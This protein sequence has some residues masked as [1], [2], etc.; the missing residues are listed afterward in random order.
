[1]ETKERSDIVKAFMKSVHDIVHCPYCTDCQKEGMRCREMKY[2]G[3]IGKRY[4]KFVVV[5]HFPANNKQYI[6]RENAFRPYYEAFKNSQFSDALDSIC[7]ENFI[8]YNEALSNY[9]R[10]WPRGYFVS[11]KE[12]EFLNYDIDNI[13]F[14]NIT[15][16]KFQNSEKQ[17][18]D[19]AVKMIDAYCFNKHF[20]NQIKI[21]NPD[22]IVCVN[23]K[24]KMILENLY[25]EIKKFNIAA[26]NGSQSVHDLAKIL[27]DV[28]P[29]FKNIDRN[30]RTVEQKVIVR[31][32][33]I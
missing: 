21:L 16:C 10:E 1:M 7:Y 15:K 3:F 22:H 30:A 18:D 23:K 19:N 17:R 11:E 2:P 24:T 20:I 13:A 28:V 9:M 14:I 29:V 8:A 32:N 31:R 25:P 12:R 26:G 5:G 27:E 4:A 6:E 33:R